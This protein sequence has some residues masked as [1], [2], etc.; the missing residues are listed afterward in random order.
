MSPFSRRS[1]LLPR[2]HSVP[3]AAEPTVELKVALTFDDLPLNGL[4]PLGAKQIR[5]RARHHQGVEKA[6]HP[7]LL[8]IHRRE[9]ARARS[10]RRQGVADLGRW[11]P[12]ARQSHLHP[13]RPHEEQ[14]RGFSARNTSQRARARTAHAS[15]PKNGGRHTRLALVPVSVPARR[16]H[17]REAPRGSRL[18]HEQRVPHR[19]D[20][21]RLR[22]L[23]L[24]QR[25]R[26]LL[27][28]KG[29][30]VTSSG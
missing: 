9:T 16:R 7:T 23:S 6:P 11:R 17:A 22:G 28:A 20:H 12:P 25:L 10:R 5:L 8:R 13:P 19:A 2:S 4:L 1:P 18:P 24:E 29:R 14:R 3:A 26:A 30:N 15:G 21:A 27:D